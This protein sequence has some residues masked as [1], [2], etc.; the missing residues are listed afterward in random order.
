MTSGSDQLINKIED[1][2]CKWLHQSGLCP[3]AET[4][5]I[6]LMGRDRDSGRMELIPDNADAMALART[7]AKFNVYTTHLLVCEICR[8]SVNGRSEEEREEVCA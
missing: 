7:L 8:K 2:A 6:D 1:F 5:F 3:E 4:L